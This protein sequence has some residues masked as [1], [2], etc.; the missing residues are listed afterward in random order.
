MSRLPSDSAP[1][2]CPACDNDIETG[3]CRCKPAPLA[4]GHS[5]LPSPASAQCRVPNAFGPLDPRLT[6]AVEVPTALIVKLRD[7]TAIGF[8]V[9]GPFGYSRLHD[10]ALIRTRTALAVL[11]ESLQHAVAAAQLAEETMRAAG[12]TD[13]EIHDEVT[14]ATEALNTAALRR[15]GTSGPLASLPSP[16][17]AH[18]LPRGVPS[19]SL[20]SQA[21]DGGAQQ[22]TARFAADPAHA[23]SAVSHLPVLSAQCQVPSPVPLSSSTPDGA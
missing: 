4:T 16:S 1:T 5:P 23:G 19:A 21:I 13:E 3:G 22:P 6:A 8:R 9:C 12:Y 20:S 14:W 17:S 2:R 7:L 15:P 18:C 10:K 11:H